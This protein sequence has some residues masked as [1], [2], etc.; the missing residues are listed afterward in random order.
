MTAQTTEPTF[1]TDLREMMT[2]YDTNRARWVAKYG[3]DD[4]FD[5]W[6]TEQA[7]G[8]AVARMLA[9]KGADDG[10]LGR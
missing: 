3:S 1:A 7:V 2:A 8:P 10:T 4:G 6:Y 5:A 9:H